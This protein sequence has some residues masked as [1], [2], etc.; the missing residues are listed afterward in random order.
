MPIL[1]EQ[2]ILALEYIYNYFYA[3][4]DKYTENIINLF[5]IKEDDLK[6]E[7]I[8]S[9]PQVYKNSILCDRV[10]GLILVKKH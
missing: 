9:F 7:E 5:N 6:F 3:R 1:D 8:I 10:S 4:I 2:G